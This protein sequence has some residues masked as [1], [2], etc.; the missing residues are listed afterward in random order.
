[1]T[2]FQLSIA[3]I[4][5]T[6]CILSRHSLLIQYYRFVIVLS[7]WMGGANRSAEMEPGRKTTNKRKDVK[8]F[9]EHSAT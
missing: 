1:M 7:H 3:T 2:L 6:P 9:T 8:R 5:S 4:V